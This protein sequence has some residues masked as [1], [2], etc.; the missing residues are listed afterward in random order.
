MIFPTLMMETV[1]TCETYVFCTNTAHYHN[2]E[3]T[4]III[5][6]IIIIIRSAIF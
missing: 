6:I 2:P 1:G 5:I 4:I 3:C